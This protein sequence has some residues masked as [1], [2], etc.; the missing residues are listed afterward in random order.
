MTEKQNP[1]MYKTITS[2]Y[3]TYTKH[4]TY[5]WPPRDNNEILP[6]VLKDMEEQIKPESVIRDIDAL[7]T[8]Y[9]STLDLL[10]K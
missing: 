6:E 8:R 4:I 7:I 5:M 3:P 1:F 9:K 10:A 2:E